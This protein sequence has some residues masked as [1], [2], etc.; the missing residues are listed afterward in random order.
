MGT[1]CPICQSR[2]TSFLTGYITRAN[3]SHNLFRGLTIRL[4]AICQAAF[5]DPMPRET[6]IQSYYR[7]QYRS[8]GRNTASADERFPLDNLWYLSRG[9]AVA[10]LVHQ[11]LGDQHGKLRYADIG[12]GYG[13]TIAAM[14]KIAEWDMD[15]LGVEPDLH[16]WDSLHKM[17]HSVCQLG[18]GEALRNQ[19]G[20]FDV[21]TALHVIEHCC[22]P[23]DALRMIKR[24]LKS[25]GILIV[26]VPNCPIGRTLA[27]DQSVPHSP[28]LFFFTSQSLRTSRRIRLPFIRRQTE[29]STRLKS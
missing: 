18:L 19:S 22:D 3:T 25:D 24:K 5:A 17:A 23:L 26:E 12:A 27:Y 14:N 15:S 6:D 4:C 16:C 10:R 29:S 20:K 13:H 2:S 7:S 21:I 8:D 1:R 11:F 9:V 28:H